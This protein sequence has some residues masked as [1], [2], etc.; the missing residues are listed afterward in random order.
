MVAAHL[1]FNSCQ[2]DMVKT[3]EMGSRQFVSVEDQKHVTVLE[4]RCNTGGFQPRQAHTQTVHF[5]N[6]APISSS[7]QLGASHQTHTST[8]SG[9]AQVSV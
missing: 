4:L 1:Q 8:F 7:L 9:A 5:F 6:A 2:A 3:Q